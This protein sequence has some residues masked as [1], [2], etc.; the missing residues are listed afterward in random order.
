VNTIRSQIN[1]ALEA[2]IEEKNGVLFQRLAIQCLRLRWPS[3]ASVTEEADLGEDAITILGE[4]SDGVIRTFACS[5]T[6]TWQKVS[7]DAHK[8]ISQRSDVRELIFATPKTL[9]RNVQKK[10]ERR[11]REEH[12][13]K[14]IV[15]ERSEFLAILE[16]P[17]SQWICREYLNLTLGYGHLL[18]NADALRKLGET[19]TALEKA[20]DAEK[21]ALGVGDWD[22]VCRAQILIAELHM[23][24]SGLCARYSEKA[25]EALSTA[26]AH[27]LTSLLAECLALRANSI[28]QTKAK[29]ARKLLEEAESVVCDNLKVKRWI[30]LIQAELEQNQG[31]PDKAEEKLRQWELIADSG[32]RVDRQS[33]HHIKFRLAAKRGNH[34]QVLH[35]LNRA[36]RI[37]RSK[38]RWVSIGWMLHEKARYLAQQ[39]NFRKAAIEAEKARQVFEKANVEERALDSALLAGHLFFECRYA[40]RSLALADYVIQRADLDQR[41]NMVQDAYQLKTRCLQTLNRLDEAKEWNQR[42]RELVAYMPQALV[43]ADIQDAM[44]SSQARDFASAEAIMKRGLERARKTGAKEE[45][46]AAIQVHWA[47]I[48]MDQGKHH[49]ARSLAE[50]ALR[51]GDRLPFKVR[52]D[53]GHIVSVAQARAPLSSVFE[54]LLN[55][56]APL[57]LAGTNK[58]ISIQ[59][60]HKE[61]LRPLLDWT[62]KWPTAIQGIYDFWGKGNLSRFILNHRG[63]PN[64]FHVSVEASTINEARQ[65]IQVLCPLVD[66]LTIL[67]KGPILSGGMVMVPVHQDYE[68]PGGWGYM[69][70][71][72]N[73]MRPDEDPE[74]W[75]WSPAMGWATLL[76]EDAA[77]FLFEEAR[78]FFESGRLFLLPALHVGCI[79][80]GHGP[81][82]R[83]FNEIT[84]ANPVLSSQGS[85][86]QAISLSSLPLPYFPDAPLSELARMVEGEGDSLL[87]TRRALRSWAKH[88]AD[89]DHFE[90]Q[91]VIRECY[92]RVE[93]ALRNVERK[94]NDLARKLEWAKLGG[95]I[96]SYI[97][98]AARFDTEPKNLVAAELTALHSELRTSPWYAYFR[99]S[100]QGYRWDLMR[101][102]SKS[103]R[104]DQKNLHPDRIYH[105][106][107]PPQAGW[108]IPI[109]VTAPTR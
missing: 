33:F 8:V 64:A 13:W 23:D 10:W 17:E 29:E 106:L 26:R 20:T 31:N 96:H 91:D 67:W 109:T 74:D 93:S 3:L 69:I 16:R 73:D 38:K 55:D 1:L 66:V 76:P 94:F 58:S 4:T 80:P 100:S 90:T 2:L 101:K 15:V 37:A 49:E 103:S 48:E 28:I 36:I 18:E 47:Q 32:R 57:E 30:Y 22:T 72:A 65:W 108:T 87:E 35:H 51:F 92:E 107:V 70:A 59:A 78:G 6:A 21:G 53:A 88:L 75:N 50:E 25:L 54:S 41:K 77:R 99:L 27:T 52:E 7:S 34:S 14:L 42:F 19:A 89:R 9:T 84:N 97:F 24:K 63:F 46:I 79:D 68:G 12:G 95:N 45:I 39:G 71:A 105:W 44:L 61:I 81:M 40:E 60:A 98:D 102:G 62:R 104:R 85:N 43:V 11:I 83:M 82:E 5:L 56:P 86:S